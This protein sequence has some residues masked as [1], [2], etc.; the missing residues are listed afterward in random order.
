MKRTI[1]TVSEICGV[2]VFVSAITAFSEGTCSSSGDCPNYSSGSCVSSSSNGQYAGGAE[3]T[4][5]DG[6]KC[7][8]GLGTDE[9]GNQV[10][11]DCGTEP[12]VG[13]EATE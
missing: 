13:D 6:G 12:K 3:K 9:V 11:V 2:V 1:L 7:G 10:W 4:H 8:Q 5:K